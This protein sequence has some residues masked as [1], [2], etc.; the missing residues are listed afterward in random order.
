L[1]ASSL[2]APKLVNHDK[3]AKRLNK[4]CLGKNKNDF[5]SFT[6]PRLILQ[7]K[8]LNLAQAYE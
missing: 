8:Q 5:P 4:A 7:G 6:W 1:K 2:E 3:K